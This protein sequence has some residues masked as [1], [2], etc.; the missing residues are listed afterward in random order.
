MIASRDGKK[1]G[2]TR[3]VPPLLIPPVGKS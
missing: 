2:G 3:I 1:T